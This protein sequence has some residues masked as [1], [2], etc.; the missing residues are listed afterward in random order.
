MTIANQPPENLTTTQ[1]D[2]QRTP[3]ST[4]YSSMAEGASRAMASEVYCHLL[5][6]HGDN[7]DNEDDNE[8]DDSDEDSGERAEG[9]PARSQTELTSLQDDG[10]TLVAD[11]LHQFRMQ[12]EL[13]GLPI[14]D[15]VTAEALFCGSPYSSSLIGGV[16]HPE[17]LASWFA[18]SM[19]WFSNLSTNGESAG[20][21]VATDNTRVTSTTSVP[22][23]LS[24]STS[25]TDGR[26]NLEQRA[27]VG[28]GAG[29]TPVDRT[30]LGFTPRW[31]PGNL[32]DF[33]R[34]RG[35]R[36]GPL[37]SEVNDNNL[38]E[39]ER[40]ARTD[41]TRFMETAPAE[42]RQQYNED[43]A[44]FMARTDLTQAQ[45]VAVLEN[46][47]AMA[48]RRFDP[49]NAM[50]SDMSR[51][52][53]QLAIAGGV[54]DVSSPRDIDQGNRG[55]CNY[56]VLQE[57]SSTLD[58]VR[59]TAQLREVALHGT[60]TGNDGFRAVVPPA[61]FTPHADARGAQNRDGVRNFSGQLLQGGGL[62]HLWQQRGQYY[63]DSDAQ[64]ENR[65]AFVPGAANP[66]SGRF[67]GTGTNVGANEVAFMGRQFGLTG[68]FML[69]QEQ[70]LTPGAPLDPAIR[71]VRNQQ[72]LLDAMQ[73]RRWNVISTHSADRYFTGSDGM[74]GRGGGHVVSAWI[75]TGADGRPVMDANG[76]PRLFTSNQWGRN[77]DRAGSVDEVW[78]AMA[79][80]DPSRHGGNAT[81]SQAWTDY[82][83][84]N[85]N[86]TRG[87]GLVTPEEQRRGNQPP[88]EGRED[89]NRQQQERRSEE[90]SEQREALA[91]LSAWSARRAEA[92][93][94]GPEFLERFLSNN[95]QPRMPN[96]HA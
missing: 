50:R 26:V 58:P 31:E 61:F 45:K 42:V 74:G 78:Q 60:Y 52:N 28:S 91:R 81:P 83:R 10:S 27:D 16:E 73:G 93:S 54:N 15:P 23:A 36:R 84:N 80:D 8:N 21:P 3:D 20:T 19:D 86:A 71:V 43:L 40:Q 7:D 35:D 63:T 24:L 90:Q 92:A 55:T 29:S 53:L 38:P 9:N 67:I 77:F 66:F 34:A 22:T 47:A 37:S 14:S 13:L 89:R 59:Y 72:D 82:D 64:R 2:R 56:A 5:N 95:P 25:V 76:R 48:E 70:W 62:N 75:Q 6:N 49:N 69:T 44:T 12:A 79:F 4:L 88:D 85:P 68:Q 18:N 46:M 94:R 57:G 65:F 87:G 51:E 11:S 41:L 17:H 39:R 33:Q 96:H 32:T 30:N 1:T